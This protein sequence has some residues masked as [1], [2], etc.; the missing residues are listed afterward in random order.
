MRKSG[1]QGRLGWGGRVR[2]AALW[3]AQHR[4]RGAGKGR[5]GAGAGKLAKLHFILQA[6]GTPGR[7]SRGW[8]S[9][10]F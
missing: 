10:S 2:G 9:S 7:C 5:L 6:R 8:D 1:A 3:P 4:E